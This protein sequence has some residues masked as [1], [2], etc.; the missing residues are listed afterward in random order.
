MSTS[1][2]S[3]AAAAANSDLQ[4][5]HLDLGSVL[6]TTSDRNSSGESLLNDNMDFSL[7]S[8]KEGGGCRWS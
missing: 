1:M 5:V 6:G 2:S 7:T 3:P 8:L 4:S